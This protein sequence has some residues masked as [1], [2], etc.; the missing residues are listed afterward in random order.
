MPGSEREMLVRCPDLGDP[1]GKGLISAKNP[2]MHYVKH[3]MRSTSYDI[4]KFS[5]CKG[6]CK[7]EKDRK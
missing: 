7:H 5:I 6:K 2:V 1:P 4:M 3:W